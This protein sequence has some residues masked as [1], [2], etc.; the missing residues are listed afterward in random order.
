MKEGSESADIAVRDRLI[1]QSIRSILYEAHFTAYHNAKT[2]QVVFL[3]Y[4][5]GI[6]Q[7]GRDYRALSKKS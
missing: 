1:S 3:S 5:T 6:H 4:S 7:F 2:G